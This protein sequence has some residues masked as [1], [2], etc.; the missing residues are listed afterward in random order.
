MQAIEALPE[1][2]APPAII[3]EAPAAEL[4]RDEIGERLIADP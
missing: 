4:P 2:T 3:A 1:V